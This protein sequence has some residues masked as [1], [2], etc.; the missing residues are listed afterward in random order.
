MSFLISF[1]SL[2]KKLLSFELIIEPV[3]FSYFS[4]NFAGFANFNKIIYRESV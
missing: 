4:T 3:V 1:W 2:K